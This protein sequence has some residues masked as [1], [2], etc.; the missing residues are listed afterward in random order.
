MDAGGVDLR[1]RQQRQ[2]INRKG[3]SQ[4]GDVELPI[5]GALFSNDDSRLGL[6][7]GYIVLPMP[8]G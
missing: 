3:V 5:V 2:R 7:A 6:Q 1:S 4:A 8:L